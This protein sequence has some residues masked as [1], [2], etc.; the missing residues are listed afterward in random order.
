MIRMERIVKLLIVIFVLL[1]IISCSSNKSPSESP[2]KN[3]VTPSDNT[4]PVDPHNPNQWEGSFVRNAADYSD[5]PAFSFSMSPEYNAY[6]SETGD[7]T[8]RLL[9]DIGVICD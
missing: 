9:E 4:Q 8:T 3:P 1:S 6:E 2:A 7:D 5:T